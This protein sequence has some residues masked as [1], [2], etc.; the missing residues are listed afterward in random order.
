MKK[1][2]FFNAEE[3][4]LCVTLK[5]Q[6]QDYERTINAMRDDQ[7]LTRVIRSNT[8]LPKA[9]T[10]YVDLEDHGTAVSDYFARGYVL[11]HIPPTILMSLPTHYRYMGF[12]DGPWV[13][14]T[15][16][17]DDMVVLYDGDQPPIQPVYLDSSN[18]IRFLSNRIVS[19]LLDFSGNHGY[20][21]NTIAMKKY[22]VEERQQ[23]AQLIGYSVSGYGDLSYVDR[24]A[25]DRADEMAHELTMQFY[26][27]F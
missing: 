3:P 11:P 12:H 8:L 22:T 6:S 15:P 25:C 10:A 13:G 24:R 9:V 20:T 4:E 14:A 23:F 19:D 21:L 18:V 7:L 16:A 2:V 1:I 26:L 27:K 5:M 17:F